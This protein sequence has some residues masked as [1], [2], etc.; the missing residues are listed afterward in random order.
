M[1]RDIQDCFISEKEVEHIHAMSLRVLSEIGVAFEHEEVLEVFRKNGARV[2]GDKVFLSEAMVNDAL[3]TVPRN[4]E[5]YGRNG[6]VFIGPDRE[7]P[8]PVMANSAG[9]V[10]YIETDDTVH[11][12]NVYDAIK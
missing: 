8:F 7:D 4:F 12:A 10:T 6:S 2:D 1:L 3:K 11:K 9:L 5:V